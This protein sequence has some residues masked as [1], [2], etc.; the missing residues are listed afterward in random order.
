MSSANP[1]SVDKNLVELTEHLNTLQLMVIK[2]ESAMQQDDSRPWQGWP[3][4]TTE[5]IGDWLIAKEGEVTGLQ[6]SS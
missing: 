2:L 4:L 3:L 5:A 6:E 1:Q